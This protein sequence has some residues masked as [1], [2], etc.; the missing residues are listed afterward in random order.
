TYI[1][2]NAD[3]RL[4]NT[5]ETGD[6]LSRQLDTVK[7]RLT[8]AESELQSTARETSLL[9]DSEA[10]TLAEEKLRQLQMALSAAESARINR[11]SEYE[12]VAKMQPNSMPLGLD[13]GM[14]D[15][16]MRLADLT[17]QRA[18]LSATMTPEH[19]K[20]RELTGQIAALE[21]ALRGE[22][23]TTVS[24]LRSDYQAAL[25]QESML[26][27]A[28]D[29]QAAVVSQR[30][31][32]AVHY[33][34]LRREVDSERKIYDTLLQRVQEVGLVA[35]L[36]TSTISIVDTAT[37]PVKPYSPNMLASV[38]IGFFGGSALGLAL[39]F[40]RLRSDRTLQN[41]GDSASY[42]Q[43]R[44]LGVIPNIRIANLRLLLER[45]RRQR[46]P[47]PRFSVP[48]DIRIFDTSPSVEVI[49]KNP[50][51]SIALG[52]WMRNTPELA[53]AYHSAMNS[54][55][56]ASGG[57]EHSRVIVLTSPE[58]GD[59]K[60]TAATNLGVALAEIGRRVVLVDGDLRKPRLGAIFGIDCDA[61]LAKFLDQPEE[62]PN[63]EPLSD[64]V[65]STQVENLFVLP[66]AS[67]QEGISAK[68]HS[69]RM[70]GLLQQLR[71]E[72]D[73]VIIDSPPMLHLSD[74]RVLGWLSDGVL[75]V[76]RSRKTT[77]EN[78]LAAADCLTQDGIRVLG[79]ILNDWNPRKG[80][81]YAAY[82]QMGMAS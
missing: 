67:T 27:A 81:R 60:T 38:G 13:G 56:F 72:F 63:Q 11:E 44:E 29:K 12:I 79:T 15:Y 42:L 16:R 69:R 51:N 35:A 33:D 80:A 31:D 77:R 22:Q 2:H 74:A 4:Q 3:S 46:A 78:A 61:G 49:R 8:R 28:Y 23:A 6:W 47:K 59:G 64:L 41:P 7:A 54:L 19:Y 40:F 70:R 52:T 26:Q 32:K 9:P 53:E 30:G 18:E 34:M 21:S 76:F 39:S 82:S 48:G 10:Q 71:Q 57:G 24:G 75:L 62:L 45:A 1:Q 68:L 36:R 5:T 17:R 58:A 55:L 43:L 65:R 66:T 20:V 14:R 25:R 73:V 50:A 37:P